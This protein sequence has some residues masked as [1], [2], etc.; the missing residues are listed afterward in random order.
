MQ[1]IIQ[2]LL[3]AHRTLD[4]EVS[5]ELGQPRPDQL[6]LARLKRQRLATKDRLAFVTAKADAVGTV[7]RDML[8]KRRGPRTANG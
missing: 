7:A 3:A 1:S 2:R 5:R 4:R 6:R 8:A